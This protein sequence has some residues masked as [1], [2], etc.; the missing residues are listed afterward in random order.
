VNIVNIIILYQLY[1]YDVSS[2]LKSSNYR[3]VCQY[4]SQELKMGYLKMQY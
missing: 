2:L 4:F 1:L 3:N